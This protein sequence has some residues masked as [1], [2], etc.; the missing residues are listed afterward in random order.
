MP[1]ELF[2]II[3]ELNVKNSWNK[4][5]KFIY[6]ETKK[7]YKVESL[8]IVFKLGMTRLYIYG[9]KSFLMIVS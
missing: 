3:T 5:E 9:V 4:S 8:K 7:D 6:I 1:I 2:I